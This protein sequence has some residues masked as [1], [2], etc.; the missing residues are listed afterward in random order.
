MIKR[1]DL[2]T[3]GIA[4]LAGLACPSVLRAQEKQSKHFFAGCYYDTALSDSST[5]C[6]YLI[7]QHMK[8]PTAEKSG[9]ELT[10]HVR[11]II[12]RKA[13][14]S[15]ILGVN[16]NDEG[17]PIALSATRAQHE[18]ITITTPGL[19]N[20]FLTTIS[21]SAA[22]D[23]MTDKA[24][25]RNQS[26]FESLYS[27]MI[28]VNQVIH[29]RARPNDLE[30]QKHYQNVFT[31]AVEELLD[32]AAKYM[33]DKRERASAVF[34]VKNMVMPN[35][36]SVDLEGLISSGV[37]ASADKSADARQRE[38]TKLGREL[39]HVYNLMILEALDR[40]K[41]TNVA[42][43][44]PE[45]PWTEGRIL[46]RLQERLGMQAQILSQAD[47]SQMNGFEIRAGVLKLDRSAG[48]G[49]SQINCTMGSRIVRR[50][51]DDLEH[52]PKSI[53]DVAKKVAVSTNA[54][55]FIERP[56]FKRGLP[57][58]VIMG[59]IRDSAR[60]TA[61]ALAPLLKSA[62]DEI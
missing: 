26:R 20:E 43:L 10:P 61:T 21:V 46:R 45:S 14:F 42:I 28:V 3:S 19:P 40:A 29:G 1:R 8:V 52:V 27:T 11:D 24:A 41:I 34:Q 47:S 23:V 22:I 30:L 62:A 51:G 9:A 37:D 59:A 58:D 17:N 2:L 54:R 16:E 53:K 4:T 57:R 39:Q 18:I 50:K 31:A 13:D 12:N 49:S 15:R 25:F 5:L 44:P 56:D 6:R 7:N 55:S 48:A 36:L 32:R 33:R 38:I 35:P 60:G